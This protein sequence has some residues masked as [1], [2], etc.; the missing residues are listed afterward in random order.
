MISKMPLIYF[1]IGLLSGFLISF[2]S[3]REVC[4]A[5]TRMHVCLPGRN[6]YL[7]RATHCFEVVQLNKITTL[8]QIY[9]RV[10]TMLI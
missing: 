9:G 8:M 4:E 10:Q 7:F 6:A 5:V 3:L 2:N 1:G